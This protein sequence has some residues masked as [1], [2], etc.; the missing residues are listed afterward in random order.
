MNERF[1]KHATRFGALLVIE[2]QPLADRRGFLERLFCAEEF[3]EMGFR[4]PIAQINHTVTLAKGTVRG[5]HFQTPP[6]AEVKLVS[7]IRGEAFDVA[8]DLRADSPTF[9]QWHAEILTAGNYR[10]LL[11]PAG[12]AHGFQT[13]T[14]NCE[15]LYFHTVAHTPAAERAISPLEPRVGISWPLPISSMSERDA[16]HP[17]LAD[18]YEGIAS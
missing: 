9:L 5:M 8:V 4:T 10:S 2:R 15:M 7:C 14:D 16:N 3:L 17:A 12:F 13:L 1:R 6:H 11:I 18:D